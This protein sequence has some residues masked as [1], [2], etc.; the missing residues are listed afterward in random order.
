[1]AKSAQARRGL[2]EQGSV[3]A[4]DQPEGS[5]GPEDAQGTIQTLDEL[6][7]AADEGEELEQGPLFQERR[8]LPIPTSQGVPPPNFRS[9]SC[10][11]AAT[12]YQPAA[13][14]GTVMSLSSTFCSS[15]QSFTFFTERSRTS[16]SPSS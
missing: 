4:Q 6:L 12:S 14:I 10:R 11:L 16:R 5:E 13:G 7:L 3:P 9:G 2:A 1:M 8:T 15:S